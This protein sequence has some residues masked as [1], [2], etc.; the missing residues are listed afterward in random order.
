MIVVDQTGQT[1]ATVERGEVNQVVEGN[2]ATSTGRSAA[3]SSC[4]SCS[5]C[6]MMTE[7][8]AKR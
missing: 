4:R 5:A 3:C 7:S 1:I 2:L 8:A 6:S